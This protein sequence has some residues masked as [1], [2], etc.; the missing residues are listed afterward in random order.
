LENE[1]HGPPL[2]RTEKY[3]DD[4]YQGK[5]VKINR[6]T[7]E[8]DTFAMDKTVDFGLLDECMVILAILHS[9]RAVQSTNLNTW[10]LSVI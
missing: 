10:A 7:N 1:S 2:Q 9:S 6:D 5:I 8:N 3:Q 4:F